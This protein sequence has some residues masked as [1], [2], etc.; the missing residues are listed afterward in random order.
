[1]ARNKLGWWRRWWV[2]RQARAGR[3]V[4]NIVE[5]YFVPGGVQVFR[6][7]VPVPAEGEETRGSLTVEPVSGRKENGDG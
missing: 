6:L 7:A 4:N 5:S 2:V 3:L 1:M